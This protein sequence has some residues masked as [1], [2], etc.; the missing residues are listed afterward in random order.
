MNWSDFREMLV[1]TH[2]IIEMIIRGTIMYLAIFLLLRVVL[3]RRAQGVSTQDVLLTVM[4]ADAAQNGMAKEYRSITEGIVLVSVILFWDWF[5]D[6]LSFHY[7]VIE[8]AIR[9]RPLPLVENGRFNR[10]NMREELVTADEL[11][12]LLREKDVHA[13]ELVEIAYLEA[14]GTL[15]VR[16]DKSGN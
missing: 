5:L 2:S 15:S 6:W 8:R 11:R 7:P 16:V 4:I 3:K 13:I 12:A 9:P 10:R 14:N 1:P